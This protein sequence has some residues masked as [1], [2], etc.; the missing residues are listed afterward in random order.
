MRRQATREMTSQSDLDHYEWR[1][2]GRKLDCIDSLSEFA[3]LPVAPDAD[4][5]RTST[6]NLAS[7][8][9]YRAASTIVG[10]PSPPKDAQD[11]IA[12]AK[13]TILQRI[14]SILD[15]GG[16]VSAA[17]LNDSEFKQFWMPDSNC[18]EC[19]ECG[20]KF[21]TF[22][23]RHHCRIC[24]R[25]FCATCCNLDMIKQHKDDIDLRL[26][27][28]CAA[29]IL[30]YLRSKNASQIAE[31]TAMSMDAD[32][33]ESLAFREEA[34]W[35]QDNSRRQFVVVESPAET[36]QGPDETP[37][38]N[39]LWK[40]T[41]EVFPFQNERLQELSYPNTATGTRLVTWFQKELGTDRVAAVAIGQRLIDAGLLETVGQPSV[42]QFVDATILYQPVGLS[43]DPTAEKEGD[44]A[45]PLWVSE[46]AQESR[47]SSEERLVAADWTKVPSA[48][49][50]TPV[51]KKVVKSDSAFHLDLNLKQSFASISRTQLEAGSNGEDEEYSR[52]RWD[53]P[54]GERVAG[55]DPAVNEAL[56]ES[57]R[58]V[59]GQLD[60]KVMP[61]DELNRI[62]LCFDSQYS[63]MEKEMLNQQLA[64]NGLNQS[65]AEI[66]IPIVHRVA[67][68]VAPPSRNNDIRNFVHVKKIPG[69]AKKDTSIVWGTA[70][71]KNLVHKEMRCHIDQP[72]VLILQGAI[73]Y[74]RNEEKIDTLEPIVM[75]EQDYVKYAIAKIRAYQ[76]DVLIVEKSVSWLV[77]ERVR[78]LNVSLI[79]NVKKS[80]ME[81][82]AHLT[83]SSQVTGLDALG[84]PTLGTCERFAVRLLDMSNSQSK[85]ITVF[86]G[87]PEHLGCSVLLRGGSFF[88]LSKLKRVLKFMIFMNYNWRLE[89][90][91]LLNELAVPPMKSALVDDEED[92]GEVRRNRTH[93]S[94]PP[95]PA[96]ATLV[97][98]RELEPEAVE[99][100]SDP[101][102]SADPDK[103]A[104]T[105]PVFNGQPPD[106]ERFYTHMQFRNILKNTLLTISPFLKISPPYME[107]PAGAS[108]LLRQYLPKE[109]YTSEKL[110]PQP[111]LIA[112]MLKMEVATPNILDAEAWCKRADIEL[113]EPHP[114][115]ALPGTSL[116]KRP[117]RENPKF[118]A[119][120]ADYRAR[121]A[122]IKKICQCRLGGDQRQVDAGKQM[123]NFYQQQKISKQDCFSPYNHQQIVVLFFSYTGRDKHPV[124]C[125]EPNFLT[126]DFYG[127]QDITLGRYL[128]RYCL[129]QEYTCQCGLQ[130]LHHTRKFIHDTGSLVLNT[131]YLEKLFLRQDCIS[132]WSFCRTC[133]YMSKVE[134]M[135]EET[136]NMSFAKYLELRFY[137]AAYTCR[138]SA[139][140]PCG[141]S[142][143]HEHYQY[144]STGHMVAAI[145]Y[146]PITIREI[147][148]PPTTIRIEEQQLN[149]S[150]ISDEIR[151]LSEKSSEFYQTVLH[152]LMGIK[153][154]VL[155]TKLEL[156]LAQI[157]VHREQKMK[158][159]DHIEKLNVQL[160]T[161]A[162]EDEEMCWPIYD[163]LVRLKTHIA[164]S[165]QTWNEL[166]TNFETARKKEDKT[167]K[168]EMN[169]FPKPPV[170]VAVVGP[171]DN[172][173]VDQTE[174]IYDPIKL[175][176]SQELRR[177]GSPGPNAAND[178]DADDSRVPS[179]TEE[180]LSIRS[181]ELSVSVDSRQ[182]KRGTVKTIFSQFLNTGTSTVI[183][184]PFPQ[185]EHYNL[186]LGMDP[187]VTVFDTEP[188]SII[189]ASL[190]SSEYQS[191]LARIQMQLGAIADSL[192]EASPEKVANVLEMKS[193][194][195]PQQTTS[196]PE[197]AQLHI[198]IQFQDASSRYYCRIYFAEQFRQVRKLLF[199]AGERRFI[200]SLAR[201]VPWQA[202]GGKSGSV[203]C[204]TLDD[205]FILKEMSRSEM[206]CVRQEFGLK[207]FDYMSRASKRRSPTVLG[208]IVGVYRIGCH[209]SAT[210]YQCRMDLL[211]MENLFYERN[212]VQKFDLKGSERNRL[213]DNAVGDDVVLLDENFMRQMCDHP[214]YIR[215]HSKKVLMDAITNDSSFLAECKV[216]DYSLLVGIDTE[217]NEFVVGVIDYVR[218]F[219]WDKKAEMIVKSLPYMKSPTVIWPADY[220]SRFQ[221]A[222]N[223]YF[224]AVPDRWTPM[225]KETYRPRDMPRGRFIIGDNDS[226]TN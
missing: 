117:L 212:I 161:P 23:R 129:Q 223:R 220:K 179:L 198:D 52:S 200:Y 139:K 113:L 50:A 46:I 175:L 221:G 69:G 172:D 32:R 132:M 225:G 115:L 38:I 68:T 224:L 99:D 118:R 176:D 209:N 54:D 3:P 34:L 197:Q 183:Q 135:S 158:C 71:S 216:M 97:E 147:V 37:D 48:T 187:P 25:I 28:Y 215:Q 218:Q 40:R 214:L 162:C 167:G 137:G 178:S 151:E 15:R 127:N 109:L 33:R 76:P 87:C 177:N 164:D 144:F 163:S 103:F 100:N 81:R 159:K 141:H 181:E 67:A 105:S 133:R 96:Q 30:N 160:I 8:L 130:M 120:L 63:H 166:L 49:K 188:S 191:T 93:A 17:N 202:Q 70:F 143:H 145:K 189:A 125:V 108:C 1:A 91:F 86:S 36:I 196:K 22:R 43:A 203:F 57:T 88:E 95:L 90:A 62:R 142:L 205:R 41:L 92:A 106:E 186:N 210:N 171:F 4:Q 65:W 94:T 19:Y 174:V 107:T 136:W 7:Q 180:K 222:M 61:E 204:K 78:E 59:G 199:P 156:W 26:C 122:R 102:R 13:H 18:K 152:A 53:L 9:L 119:L 149:V 51:E 73:T 79:T 154:Q 114:F 21:S 206:D 111:A 10:D 55:D 165:V 211:I 85:S 24:G 11:S 194:A 84:S 45:D 80:V 14:T 64:S 104:V 27:Q 213:V 89:K 157:D 110:Q 170:D 155:G 82:L 173:S 101:L 128:E 124:F 58:H 75:Q 184:N 148:L 226:V 42:R 56:L 168:G 169:S 29:D 16:K 140:E 98:I 12:E 112:P 185:S 201:C 146:I 138:G 83:G 31:S 74:Q 5:P 208:K 39:A 192:K 35:P 195:L 116:G 131:C 126:M 207:Y 2:K 150:K 72:K 77:R 123:A 134:S 121:G 20:A 153:E 217:R 60:E 219:T 190:A 193:F 182:E 6:L 47:S 66:I 44:N